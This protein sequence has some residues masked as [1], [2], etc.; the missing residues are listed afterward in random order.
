MKNFFLECWWQGAKGLFPRWKADQTTQKWTDIG[1]IQDILVILFCGIGDM[2]VFVPALEALGS[3]FCKSHFTIMTTPHAGQV[4]ENHPCVHRLSLFDHIRQKGFLEKFDL[5]INLSGWD[6]ELNRILQDADVKRLIIKNM[7]FD[8]AYPLHAGGYHF[9]CVRE[10]TAYFYKPLVYINDD[11]RESARKYLIDHKLNPRSDPLMAIHAGSSNPDKNWD[12]RRF[13]R[14][15]R[16]LI[17]DYGAKILLLTG[18]DE[19]EISDKIAKGISEDCVIVSEPLRLVAALLQRSTLLVTNDSGIMHLGT[20]VGTPLVGIFGTSS[21]QPEI[22]GPLGDDHVLICK[23]TLDEIRV[24][25][26]KRSIKRLFKR[27]RN[28]RKMSFNESRPKFGG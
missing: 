22:W 24:D 7:K 21:S 5:I 26:V 4:L 19:Q 28:R 14:L 23:E 20:A 13:G 9:E 15:C 25:D 10:I 8:K 2:V 16:Y 1:S 11:E 12:F 3:F 18:P 27:M 6:A 17:S